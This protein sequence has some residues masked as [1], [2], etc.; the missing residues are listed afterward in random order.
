[1]DEKFKKLFILIIV[2]GI[3]F[4]VAAVGMYCLLNG[5][6]GSKLDMPMVFGCLFIGGGTLVILI[7]IIKVIASRVRCSERVTGICIDLRRKRMDNHGGS[8]GVYL[9]VF[10]Y[11]YNGMTY[12][13]APND[14]YTNIGVPQINQECRIRVNPLKPEQIYYPSVRLFCTY[15]FSGL[16]FIFFGIVILSV[17]PVAGR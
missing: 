6:F 2:T 15:I 10:Q 16:V 5:D 17:L 4:P 13:S 3:L 8:V 11:Y 14:V 9:P 7:R 12:E 1:M